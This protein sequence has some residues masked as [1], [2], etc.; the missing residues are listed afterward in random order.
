MDSNNRRYKIAKLSILNGLLGKDQN[1]LLCFKIKGWRSTTNLLDGEGGSP[2]TLGSFRSLV[3]IRDLEN[4]N[5]IICTEEG[6]G[7]LSAWI[8][9]SEDDDVDVM[10]IEIDGDTENICIVGSWG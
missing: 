4:K 10:N 7:N 3:S 5:M 2:L 6:I 8:D 1:A 9:V